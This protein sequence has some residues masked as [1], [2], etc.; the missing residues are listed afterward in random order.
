MALSAE[1]LG[2]L[3]N[4]RWHTTSSSIETLL[5]ERAL[6]LFQ[7]DPAPQLGAHLRSQSLLPLDFLILFPAVTMPP[8]VGAVM[9]GAGPRTRALPDQQRIVVGEVANILGQSV[10]KAMADRFRLS[11]VLSVPQVMEGVKAA[12]LGQALSGAGGRRDTV[13]LTRVEMFS[14]S[15]SAACTMV[16]ILDAGIVGGFL[17]RVLP[18]P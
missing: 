1:R 14:D 2:Q 17:K 3:S 4:T 10:V 13:V 7:N 12:I 5:V 9:S 16:L 11:I 8:L 15:I 6:T 18:Q